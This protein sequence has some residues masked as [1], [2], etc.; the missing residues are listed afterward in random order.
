MGA[1]YRDSL[2][3]RQHGLGQL[4]A[5]IVVEKR[6]RLAGRS[7]SKVL[8]VAQVGVE[9]SQFGVAVGGGSVPTFGDSP[10]GQQRHILDSFEQQCPSN[11]G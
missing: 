11:R 9:S 4:V 5:E 2:A 7:W 8:L 1:A 3:H 10:V 6:R